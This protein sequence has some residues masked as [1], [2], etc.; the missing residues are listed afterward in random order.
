[1]DSVII[2]DNP[3]NSGRTAFRARSLPDGQGPYPK[4]GPVVRIPIK[5]SIS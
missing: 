1:V 2:P 5:G 3:D 4:Y